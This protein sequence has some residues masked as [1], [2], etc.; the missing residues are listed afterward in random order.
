MALAALKWLMIG[1]GVSA[2]LIGGSIFL[3]GATF[4]GHL[5]EAMANAVGGGVE[6]TPPFSPTVESELRFYAVLWMAYGG[7]LIWTARGLPPRL[8][9]VPPLA[10]VFFLGGVGRV[11]A[12]FAD[13][14]PHPAFVQLMAVELVLPV[15]FVGLWRAARRQSSPAQ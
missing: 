13:G 7:V 3:A 4:T 12:F 5:A 6:L 10:G 14:P 8:N 2:L 15:V 1:L 11:I 9:W